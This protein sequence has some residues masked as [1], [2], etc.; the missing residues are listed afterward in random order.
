[1]IIHFINFHIT[2]Q[3]DIFNYGA[4][5]LELKPTKRASVPP[6]SNTSI[7]KF[8]IFHVKVIKKPVIATKLLNESIFTN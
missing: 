3:A 5:L 8:M 1:M 6:Q 4:L 2:A 7:L